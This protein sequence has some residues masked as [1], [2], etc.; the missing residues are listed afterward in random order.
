MWTCV[1]AAVGIVAACL[2]NLRPLFKFSDRGFWTQ[3]R[4]SITGSKKSNNESKN[5]GTG[6]STTCSSGNPSIQK[7]PLDSCH[8]EEGIEIH[9][10]SAIINEKKQSV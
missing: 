1:E 3:L 9:R 10:Y 2:P 6:N 4:S 7:G 8:A 5:T